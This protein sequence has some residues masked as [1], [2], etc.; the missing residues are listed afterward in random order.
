MIFRLE[1][2]EIGSI[3]NFKFEWDLEKNGLLC[4]AGK[5]GS[6]KTTLAKAILNFSLADIFYRTSSDGLLCSNSRI[7]YFMGDEQYLFTYNP[8]LQTLDCRTPIP[9]NYKFQVGVEL[10]VPY[11]QR[12]N[13]FRILS[14]ADHDIRREIILENYSKPD[15]LIDFLHK[16][17]GDLR[18]S[19]LI[20]VAIKG[21]R[22]YCRLLADG[23]YLR[24]DYFSSGEYFLTNLFRKVTLGQ[25]FIFIDEIDISLDAVAQT[26]VVSELRL[27][28]N[29]HSVSIVFTSHSLAM[30]QTMA[31]G[32]ITYMESNSSEDGLAQKSFG[33]IKSLMFGFKGYD[34]YILTEDDVLMD[35]L[36]FLIQRYCPPTFFSYEIIYIGG[37]S[38]VVDLMLRNA[39]KEFFGA[40][41]QVISVLD[42]DQLDKNHARAPNIHCIPIDNVELDFFR[43][44][45]E[46]GYTPAIDLTKFN[47]RT[48]HKQIYKYMI[49]ERLLSKEEIFDSICNHHHV[50]FENFSRIVLQ[51]F[52]CRPEN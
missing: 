22:Y 34:R 38:Q 21:N 23:R 26:R 16:I 51:P 48:P 40:A 7:N 15:E 6:G 27:L 12:F 30:M 49:S 45:H 8:A 35:F 24:E 25:K 11:G 44:C 2:F 39:D 1:I 17:Y 28:C 10:P 3:K 5:N 29:K 4:I 13:F 43:I 14:E 36:K 41:D 50:Q 42:G 32:E 33:Y 20:E 9:S 52:L 18:F 31:P 46:P 19:D 37:G 47:G